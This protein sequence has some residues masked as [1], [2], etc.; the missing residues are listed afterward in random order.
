MSSPYGRTRATR[1]IRAGRQRL[2]QDPGR[3]FI[4]Q[5]RG[6]EELRQ[7][8]Q[9]RRQVDDGSKDRDLH[10]IDR[11]DFARDRAARGNPDPDAEVA[12]SQLAVPHFVAAGGG[13]VVNVSSALSHYVEPGFVAYGSAK[14]ALNHM[15]RMLA[16]ELAPKVRVNAMAVGSIETDALS[17]FLEAVPD[18][19]GKMEAMT[20]M[21]RLGQP[22][23]VAALALYL[24][25][26]ASSWV[27]G[28]VFEVDGGTVA[29]NWPLPLTQP[30]V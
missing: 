25:S 26:P 6:P 29:S 30:L 1:R 23:D 2:R 28:K 12:L 7:A 4:D 21:R 11:A 15:T 19:R 27:T 20:P 5:D 16:A 24:A 13:A 22:E 8:F 9:A 17:P 10:L 14:A 18:L 3:R